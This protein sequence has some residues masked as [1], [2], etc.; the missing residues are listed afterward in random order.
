[1]NQIRQIVDTQIKYIDLTKQGHPTDLIL[2]E[3]ALYEF[4]VNNKSLAQRYIKRSKKIFDL[5]DSD[6]AKWLDVLIDIHSDY[7][8]AVLNENKN[9]FT[10]IEDNEFVKYV[11]SCDDSSLLKRVRFYSTY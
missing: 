8:N 4:H 7:I 10:N 6:I 9:Y 5:G 11:S 1:M 2:R 3:L